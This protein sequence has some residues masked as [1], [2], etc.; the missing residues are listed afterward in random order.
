MEQPFTTCTSPS[1]R[2]KIDRCVILSF[3]VPFHAARSDAFA[4]SQT[5]R[6]AYKIILEKSY[7]ADGSSMQLDALRKLWKDDEKRIGVDPSKCDKDL[8]R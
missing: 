5:K 6:I 4:V 3:L 8:R 1:S 2:E 7:P